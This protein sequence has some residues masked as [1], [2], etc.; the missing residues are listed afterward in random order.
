MQNI[1]LY[2]PELRPRNEWM[3]AHT[4]LVSSIGFILLLVCMGVVN[5][6]RLGYLQQEVD[7]LEFQLQ[8]A[9]QRVE[10]IKT[11]APMGNSVKLDMQIAELKS[12]INSRLLVLDLIQSQSLGN[13][14]GYSSRLHDLALASSADMS[15][16]RFRFSGG[17]S[18]VEMKGLSQNAEAVAGLVDRLKAAESFNSASF[19]GLTI[20]PHTT[21]AM[22]FEFHL[23]FE[24]LF[25]YQTEQ[26]VPRR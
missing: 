21:N 26:V 17:A 12:T 6:Y 23:G 14:D 4:L 15:I 7:D 10:K 24:P 9:E 11:R 25:N 3:T 2:L 8:L 16:G 13:D 19:G 20:V 22:Q 18:L 1:N 5:S